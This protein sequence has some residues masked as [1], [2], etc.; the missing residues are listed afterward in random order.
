MHVFV[1]A[2]IPQD[3]TPEE[4]RVLAAK[5]RLEPP[6]FGTPERQAIVDGIHERMLAVEKERAQQPA[7]TAAQS[8]ESAS[9]DANA[10]EAGS[11]TQA[12]DITET[13]ASTVGVAVEN[14]P[15]TPQAV[16][17]AGSGAVVVTT[18]SPP[19]TPK[20][21]VAIP[22]KP[23]STPSMPQQ[24]STHT[25]AAA[26]VAAAAA[27]AAPPPPPDTWGLTVLAVALAVLILAILLRKAVA[28]VGVL[29]H[30]PGHQ[31]GGMHGTFTSTAWPE[32]DI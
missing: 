28:L 25:A 16:S 11:G 29:Q 31:D 32:K 24:P 6:K 5:S 4:R 12:A 26:P 30:P 2:C 23:P 1:H 20:P 19:I 21:S 27:A 17:K 10:T 7:T 15:S 9:A 18:N 13:P 8:A 3:W 14:K 22:T